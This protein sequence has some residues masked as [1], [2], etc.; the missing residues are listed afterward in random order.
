[1]A[2]NLFTP[3]DI[4]VKDLGHNQ[5]RITLE[6]FERGFGY[7]LG[8]ALRRI[9]LA[10]M[11]GAAPVK[12]KIDG[13]LHEYG[14]IP[15]VQ[16]DVLELLLNLKG[17]GFKLFNQNSAV[18][19]LTKK[20]AGVVTAGDIQLPHDVEV[21]NPDY[22]IAHLNQSAKLNMEIIV[23]KGRGYR[24]A[25]LNHDEHRNK[26]V[27]DLL[28]DAS[29][30][31]IRKVAYQVD[32]ARVGDQTDFDKLVLE[33]ETN[34]TIDPEQ[35]LRDAATIL[36]QQLSCFIELQPSK[37]LD[38]S[39]ELLNGKNPLLSHPVDE[40]ELTVRSAN[41]LKAEK[42]FT[43]KDLVTHTELELLHT[44]NLGKKSLNEIK[45]VL[46]AHGLSLGMDVEED[47]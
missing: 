24:P 33:I 37:A 41:C 11:Q 22:V 42:I 4:K 43:I 6:P 40:L 10:W 19:R 1:M 13:V 25:N 7:T 28:L 27:G 16:E 2:D 44:P 46:L 8:N 15:G 31:P 45:T 17:I 38:N 32:K 39:K 9:L 12:A 23:E 36:Q 14:T 5:V 26:Q 30:S 21:V 47:E 35:A 20:G 34:G 3:R 29:F 18:L